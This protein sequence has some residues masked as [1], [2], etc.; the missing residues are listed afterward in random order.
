MRDTAIADGTAKSIQRHGFPRYH[1]TV[2]ASGE[3]TEQ[4]L[5]DDIAKMFD[6]LKPQHEMAT[7]ADVKIE[8]IDTQGVQN[9][10]LYSEWSTQRVTA[11]FGVP[12]EMLGLGRGVLTGQIRQQEFY[13]KIGTLQKRF[14]RQWNVQ[15]LDKWAEGTGGKA[16][17][18][19]LVFNDVSPIDEALTADLIQKLTSFSLDPN[20]VV[21]PQ[22]CRK[23]LGISEDEYQKDMDEQA[24]IEEE[25]L[26]NAPQPL[27]MP[28][29]FPNMTP[30][31]PK[32]SPD[33]I[34]TKKPGG[35]KQ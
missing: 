25:A 21:S 13:D 12:E 8:N 4:T 30:G 9:T 1:I 19:K 29:P 2:G 31:D 33:E 34:S 23:R 20:L 10:K 24:K 11:A 3:T 15:I 18:A 22:W 14:A 17:D 6:D 7:C 32:G 16:G 5:I 35:V 27:P 26:K 28:G